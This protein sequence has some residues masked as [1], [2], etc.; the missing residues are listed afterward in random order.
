MKRPPILLIVITI[1]VALIVGWS[2]YKTPT[3]PIETN[4]GNHESHV[5]MTTE[6]VEK[7][8]PDFHNVQ[9][10]DTLNTTPN[11]DFTKLD[12]LLSK[13][14]LQ[15]LDTAIID[16]V[17]S[18]NISRRDKIK[19]L[20]QLLD[21]HKKDDFAFLYLID[22][23]AVLKPIE[24][25][26]QITLLYDSTTSQDRKVH[27][28]ALLE[29]STSILNK[30]KQN[31][32]QI[33]YITNAISKI[34][35]FIYSQ[36]ETEKNP[37]LQFSILSTYTRIAPEDQKA[38]VLS[39]LLNNRYSNIPKEDAKKL[40]TSVIIDSP[41]LQDN[42]VSNLLGTGEKFEPSIYERLVVELTDETLKV[43]LSP[44]AKRAIQTYLQENGKNAYYYKEDGALNITEH[45]LSIKAQAKL[46][47]FDSGY[48]TEKVL[49][50]W[51]YSPNA[52]AIEKANIL[53]SSDNKTR[54]LI[55]QNPEYP[56]LANTLQASLDSQKLLSSEINLI[57]EALSDIQQSP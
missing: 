12:I 5:F 56:S 19:T 49:S 52:P 34:Q 38:E 40:A 39:S 3:K 42:M 25:T 53:L 55:Q 21:K 17:N 50:D 32:Q 23:L 10:I 26:D 1:L 37:L 22:T 7:N 31:D 14:S 45:W 43:E 15:E 18:K 48:T 30:S 41:S 54:Q 47:T 6:N 13:K 2:Y 4:L 9:A 24:I 44:Y 29:D 36:I 8:T 35:S 46:N 11:H 20:L 33:L 57:K 51:V 27:L 16:F 28:L